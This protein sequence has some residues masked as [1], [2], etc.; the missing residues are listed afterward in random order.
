M[1]IRTFAAA[2]FGACVLASTPIPVV[3]TGAAI[4]MPMFAPVEAGQLEVSAAFARATLPGAPTG[5]A[6]ITITNKGSSPDTLLSVRSP[7]AGMVALHTMSMAGSV[8][9]MSDL[10]HGID[11]AP[12]ATVTMTPDGL[13]MMFEHLTRPF[14]EGKTVVVTLTFAKA[15]SVDVD[16]PVLGIAATAPMSGMGM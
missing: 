6:Y 9:K 8:M 16:I 11:I 1:T 3:A 4:T 7:A 13:H 14:V 2:A 15:G 5:G 12:G 10:P